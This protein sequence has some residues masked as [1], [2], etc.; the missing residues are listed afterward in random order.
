MIPIPCPHGYYFEDSGKS[1]KTTRLC[2][3]FEGSG[4]KGLSGFIVRRKLIED[5]TKI[6]QDEPVALTPE[7]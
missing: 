4:F 7:R 2:K 5:K 1:Y 6:G 3:K